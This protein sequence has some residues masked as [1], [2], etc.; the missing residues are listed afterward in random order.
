MTELADY[1]RR[2][3]L[4]IEVPKSSMAEVKQFARDMEKPVFDSLADPDFLWEVNAIIKAEDATEA[5]EEH[6]RKYP[7]SLSASLVSYLY[8]LTRRYLSESDAVLSEEQVM[9]SLLAIV[10]IGVESKSGSLSGAAA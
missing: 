2:G 8:Q 6:E 9:A 7:L 1:G 4:N 10:T 3:I 5:A